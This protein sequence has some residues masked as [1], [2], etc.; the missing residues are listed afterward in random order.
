MRILRS[1][2][3]PPARLLTVGPADFLERGA[4]RAK[5]VGHDDLRLPMLTH[6]F[7]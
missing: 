4:M 5:L 3:D 6:S 7:S 1:I 2:V